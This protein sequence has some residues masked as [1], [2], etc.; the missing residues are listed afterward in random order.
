MNTPKT[1]DLSANKTRQVFP[2][3]LR[4]FAAVLVILLHVQ[5]DYLNHASNFGKPF[6]WITVYLNE[7]TRVGVPI[8]FMLSGYLL[9][10]G[11]GSDNILSFYRSRFSKLILPFLW[12][13]CVYYLFYRLASGGKLFDMAFVDQMLNTGTAYHLW[14]LY[15]LGMLYL[16][17]PFLKMI[18]SH[19]EKEKKTWILLLL[20]VLMTWQTTLKPTLN[21]IF[22]PHLYFYLSADGIVGYFGY[23]MLGYILGKHEIPKIASLVIIGAGIT[24]FAVFPL[25]LGNDIITSGS[26]FWNGGYTINHYIEAAAVFLAA[27][28]LFKPDFASAHGKTASVLSYLSSLTFH[29]YIVHVLMLEFTDVFLGPLIDIMTPS[30]SI[31]FRFTVVLVSSFTVSAIWHEVMKNSGTSASPIR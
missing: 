2:D 16:F 24:S 7:F 13:S 19:A 14:Y 20:L 25:I 15:S 26:F 8:F 10:S 6:W 1:N 28:A 17:I 18:V 21:M 23:A 12:A 31:L 5:M 29:V 3:T 11:K 4:I 22:S 30:V 9:L 27:K